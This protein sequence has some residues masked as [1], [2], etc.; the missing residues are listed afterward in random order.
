MRYIWLN[1]N[2][3]SLNPIEILKN[4]PAILKSIFCKF[5]DKERLSDTG[6]DS[7]I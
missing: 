3:L 5:S 4:K 6:T 7:K 2:I 1:L